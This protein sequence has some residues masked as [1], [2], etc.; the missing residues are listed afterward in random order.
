MSEKE[1]LIKYFEDG[2]IIT[3]IL[4]ISTI[5]NR[6]SFLEVFPIENGV[7]ILSN[8]LN[9]EKTLI[10]LW[11]NEKTIK[12]LT[13]DD[14]TIELAKQKRM[15]QQMPVGTIIHINCEVLGTNEAGVGVD[16]LHLEKIINIL[17]EK[18]KW[19]FRYESR[20]S[21]FTIIINI[22]SLDEKVI[23]EQIDLVQHFID[24]LAFYQNLGIFIFNVGKCGSPKKP[25]PTIMM[26]R[27]FYRFQVPSED[28]ITKIS[29]NY[30]SNG[31]KELYIAAQG[32]NISY[33]E[34]A[35]SN[36]VSVLWATVETIFGNK[37][38]HLLSNEEIK[39]LIESIDE[40]DILKSENDK[41]RLQKLKEIIHDPGVLSLKTRN[42]IIAS[43]IAEEL[44]LD[45][46][47][48]FQKIRFVS[49]VRGKN[50]HKLRMDRLDE[51][52]DAEQY[53]Q[54][55]LRAFIEKELKAL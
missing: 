44:D 51:L 33:V 21:T 6:R 3:A 55:I 28:I 46:N 27:K 7:E 53:L 25:V 48:T 4:K 43:S 54:K 23:N 17:N 32:L 15:E 42:E 52:K 5:N 40:L 31:K 19:E 39:V 34:K 9:Q 20:D 11:K 10:M 12:I 1:K 8:P 24:L 16:C 2:S 41:Y 30:M 26:G 47:N 50:L 37:K 38:E 13:D 35:L 18:T 49:K 45:Y 29:D 22:E 14:E 36:R